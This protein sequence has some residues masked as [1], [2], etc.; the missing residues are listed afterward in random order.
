MAGT[1]QS[2]HAPAPETERMAGSLKIGVRAPVAV[3]GS[4]LTAA[5]LM[6]GEV[7]QHEPLSGLSASQA[8]SR[9]KGR[10]QDIWPT[11]L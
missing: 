6:M 3:V 2:A 9:E 11:F 10:E 8:R 5:R 1:L 4:A 7:S